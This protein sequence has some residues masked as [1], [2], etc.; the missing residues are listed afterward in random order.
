MKL[1]AARSSGTS[2]KV[3]SMRKMKPEEHTDTARKII[4]ST[5][6]TDG[7]EEEEEE[8]RKREREKEENERAAI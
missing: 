7:Q 4:S 3:R 6:K 1:D 5:T 2:Y 8:K